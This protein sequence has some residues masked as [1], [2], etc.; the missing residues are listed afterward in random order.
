MTGL[1]A[2]FG[3]DLPAPAGHQPGWPPAAATIAAA[4]A[5]RGRQPANWSAGGAELVIQA[6]LP[7]VHRIPAGAL[8][9]A[10]S[11][12]PS[13]IAAAYASGGAAG[14][15][16]LGLGEYAVILA[17][18]SRNVLFLARTPAGPPLY[19]AR[20]GPVV[21]AAS[22][23]AGVLA[24]GL[25]AEPDQT[26][27]R[28]FLATGAC[29]DQ[30][31]TFYAG[32]RRVLPGQVVEVTRTPTGCQVRADPPAPAPLPDPAQRLAALDFT[33]PV[34]VRLGCGAGAAAVLG[35]ALAAHD[36]PRPLP[37]Y[38]AHFP[39]LTAVDDRGAYCAGTLL[40]PSALGA[41]R[42][43]ALP[44]FLDEVD[45]DGYLD[46]LGEPTPSL[47]DWLCWATA[48]RVAGDVGVLV[49]SMT[50][51]QLS[52]LTDR[53]A[54]RYGVVVAQPL[55]DLTAAAGRAAALTIA[56]RTLP[57]AAV[58]DTLASQPDDS[59]GPLL[60]ELLRGLQSELVTTFLDPRLPAYLGPRTAADGLRQ[61]LALLSGGADPAAV[62]R[63]Y[64]VER[65][66]RRPP[67]RQHPGRA[68]P[69]AE[70]AAPTSPDRAGGWA[71]VPVRTEL[72]QPGDRFLARLAWYAS[73]AAAGAPPGRW[74]LLLAAKPL[75]VAQGRARPLWEIR[76]GPTARLLHRLAG[77][78]LAAAGAFG[79]VTLRRPT[80]GLSLA[81]PWTLQVAVE[82]AGRCR[83]VAATAVALLG[84]ARLAA[85][86]AGPAARSV[87]PPRPGAPPPAQVAVTSAP[88]EPDRVAAQLLTALRTTLPPDRFADL[89]GCAVVTDEVLGWATI[90][91][92]PPPSADWEQ[93]RAFAASDPFDPPSTP[94]VL[95]LP[96]GILRPYD[97]SG[98]PPTG[99]TAGRS[100]YAGGVVR[101]VPAGPGAPGG[102]RRSTQDQP[103]QGRPERGE[104]G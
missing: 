72:L 45:V 83:L 51:P 15:R 27:V 65:W 44:F 61:V 101:H 97:Q 47:S 81:G 48:R 20:H 26:V 1:A 57:D 50:G 21:L 82:T 80:A 30:A 98:A 84:G 54:S 19:W 73:E 58:T 11:A 34:G 9:L 13:D 78:R 89:A 74:W 29:D 71:V 41:A 24:G 85:R 91:G 55:A 22:E 17:D 62:W 68:A 32:V 94:M 100:E 53:I 43:R 99:G 42:H 92:E 4:L 7:M 66:L 40:G 67:F 23:P 90:S 25:P 63:R 93:L 10:G 95:A 28:R 103:G 49:D 31:A 14:L 18:L 64:L 79:G 96:A 8:V 2:V 12:A 35:S 88:A 37:V 36:R 104:G 77:R 76:P 5:V 86:I 70:W 39:E 3:T 52:R 87:R 69:P 16:A 38:S 56:E 75:A 6:E 46:D 59:T 33:G 60:P 102:T